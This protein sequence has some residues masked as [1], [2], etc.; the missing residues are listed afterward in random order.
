MVTV[1]TDVFLYS[2]INEKLL[3][4]YMALVEQY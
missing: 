3:K 2:L 4:R 1:K